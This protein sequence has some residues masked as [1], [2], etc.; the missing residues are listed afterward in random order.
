[1]GEVGVLV[2]K[3]KPATA[4]DGVCGAPKGAGSDGGGVRGA[5]PVSLLGNRTYLCGASVS[6]VS[7]SV[8]SAGSVIQLKREGLTGHGQFGAKNRVFEWSAKSRRECI[9]QVNA[10][11]WSFPMWFIVLTWPGDISLAPENGIEARRQFERLLYRIRRRYG[12]PVGLWKKE[13]QKRGVIHYSLWLKRVPG[14][15][16]GEIEAFVK[17][18]WHAIAGQGDEAH[19]YKGAHVAAW[20][21]SPVRYL[22]GE[23]FGAGKEYQNQAPR[24]FHTGRW[25]GLLGGLKPEWVVKEESGEA[26]IRLHRLLRAFLK[27]KGYRKSGYSNRGVWAAMLPETK[28]RMLEFV[29]LEPDVG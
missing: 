17:Q 15:S 3:D 13:F 16:E 24:G 22:K 14:V 27:S 11:E 29:G 2:G 4:S 10:I 26:G 7:Y 12:Q 5:A 25:W 21:G 9:R 20:E 1:M 23:L 6:P 18:S 28:A 19:L 8:S